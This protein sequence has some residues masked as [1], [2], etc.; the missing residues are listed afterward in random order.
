MRAIAGVNFL[1]AGSTSDSQSGDA[2]SLDS[3]NRPP[4]AAGRTRHVRGGRQ[5]YDVVFQKSYLDLAAV[6]LIALSYPLGFGTSSVLVI[7][8]IVV[9]TNLSVLLACR[10]VAILVL[11]GALTALSAGFLTYWSDAPFSFHQALYRTILVASGLLSIL[12]I[13]SIRS[14]LADKQLLVSYGVGLFFSFLLANN[15]GLASF[16][17]ILALPLA[18]VFG[19]LLWQRRSVLVVYLLLGAT[20]MAFGARSFSAFCLA[21]ALLHLV[22]AIWGRRPVRSVEIRFMGVCA[23]F[24]AL[25]VAFY[26]AGVQLLL[27]G[28]LGA[29]NREKTAQQL[30]ATGNLISSARPEWFASINLGLQSPFGKGP[31]AIPLSS[32]VSTARTGLLRG[33]Y[34]SDG[35]YVRGYMLGGHF[36]LHSVLADLWIGFGVAGFAF[37]LYMLFL[38]L[39]HLLR[40]VAFGGLTAVTAFCSLNAIWYLFFGPITSNLYFVCFAVALVLPMRTTG[41]TDSASRM[42]VNGQSVTQAGLVE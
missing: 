2:M 19:G 42:I 39:R 17:F 40:G 36:N 3:M 18:L 32:D 24:A 7:S 35:D 15:M 21:A 31:G 12:A 29:Q 1:L 22:S 20:G 37:G 34:T 26:L 13:Y 28:L 6:F 23:F 41:K 16:K 25:G 4:L 27:S 14:R 33:G 11:L 38:L 5:K 30:T 10:S 8:S 9:V